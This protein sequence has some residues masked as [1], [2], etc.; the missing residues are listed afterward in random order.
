MKENHVLLVTTNYWP[1]P[2]GTAPFATDLALALH[3]KG[4]IVNVLTTYP[5][6][7]WWSVPIEYQELPNHTKIEDAVSVLRT[8][9]YIPKS[10]NL[11]TR[12]LYEFS[13]LKNLMKIMKTSDF[14]NVDYVVTIGSSFAGHFIGKKFA[15]KKKIPLLIVIHDLI[16]KGLEQSGIPGG[17]IIFKLVQSL[18]SS[19]LKE[20]AGIAVISPAMKNALKEMGVEPDKVSLIPLY[21]TNTIPELKP[22]T[23]KRANGWDPENFVVVHS[24]NMGNKQNLE[25][26]IDAAKILDSETDITFY[27]VGH[28]N[29][30]A[31][32]KSLAK[33]L[34]NFHF[35]PAV[36]DKDFP[37]ILGGADLL[38]VSERAS[39]LEMSLPSKLT[40]YFFSNRP[41]IASV[42]IAGATAEYLDGLAQ[43]VPAED[44]KLLAEKIIYM[45]QN[46]AYRNSLAKKALEFAQQNLT[47]ENGR[48]RYVEWLF[49]YTRN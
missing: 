39:Q 20:A 32:L 6:Y 18:E 26:L 41:V 7:P 45:K 28:G 15:K 49:D 16:G 48:T 33:G 40:S 19:N 46:V 3:F 12:V 35:V 29:Q 27:L 38:L 17:R 42:P 36:A 11:I 14:S 4:E 34:K 13:L 21:S 1:E 37:N 25:T 30:E 5:H 31:H 10:S 9:H 8:R 22:S 43:I 24:G 2:T 23:A 44:P 47:R